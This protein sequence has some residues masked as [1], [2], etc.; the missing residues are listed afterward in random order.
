MR[1]R[2]RLERQPSKNGGLRIYVDSS[3]HT[4]RSEAAGQRAHVRRREDVAYGSGH[5]DFTDLS[6]VSWISA[7]LG[8]EVFQEDGRHAYS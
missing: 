7:S 3:S 4:K 6:S 2:R 1:P 5:P 8:P